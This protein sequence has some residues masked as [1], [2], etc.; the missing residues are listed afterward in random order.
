M[1]AGVQRYSLIIAGALFVALL[2]PSVQHALTASMTAQMLVQIPLLIAVGWLVRDALPQRLK[3]A[4]NAWNHNGITGLLLAVCATVFWMLPR[5]LDAA[6][7]EPLMIASKLVSVPLLIGLPLGLSWPRMGF[8]VRGL[9]IS[10]LIAMFFRIG[11]VYLVSQVRLCSNYLLGDQQR[12]GEYMLM[13]GGA[14]L[15][16]V[17]VK[18]LCGHFVSLPDDRPITP[19][20]RYDP[21]QLGH[22]EQH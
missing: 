1:T 10:E 15:L 5:S 3:T 7:N 17:V 21:H 12:T 4:I 6:A 2:L 20:R 16:W 13:I 18:L 14:I 11:W 22:H 9:F 8:V 19:S